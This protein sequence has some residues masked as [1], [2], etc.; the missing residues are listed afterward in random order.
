MV[1]TRPAV[2]SRDSCDDPID[3]GQPAA[4]APMKGDR[5]IQQLTQAANQNQLTVETIGF[6]G[7]SAKDQSSL[8]RKDIMSQ[9]TVDSGDTIINHN[10]YWH[11]QTVATVQPSGQLYGYTHSWDTDQRP[12]GT[13]FHGGVFL[14]ITDTQHNLLY[15]TPPSVYGV[16]G[17]WD[18]T[19]PHN[20]Q[21][22]LSG[23]MDPAKVPA[24]ASIAIAQG[25]D[26]HSKFVNEIEQ[27][28]VG[29]MEK[30]VLDLLQWAESEFSVVIKWITTKL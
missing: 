6:A 8:E 16:C 28:L 3:R 10:K 29:T 5:H 22:P 26:P 21:D 2:Q 30:S 24:V 4:T 13:G 7:R 1:I 12:W 9:V 20:R 17:G 27:Q 19:G 25:Y 23:A 15:F 14:T 18:F 11:M